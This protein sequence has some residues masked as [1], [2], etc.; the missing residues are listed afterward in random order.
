MSSQYG[1]RRHGRDDAQ[2]VLAWAGEP[3]DANDV[4]LEASLQELALDL[5]GDGVE[6][7]VGVREDGRGGHGGGQRVCEGGVGGWGR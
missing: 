3:T 5:R 1:R 6:T 4:E 7:H 2:R